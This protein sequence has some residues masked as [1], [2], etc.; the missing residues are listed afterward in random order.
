MRELIITLPK[1]KMDD[2]KAPLEV[3]RSKL[4]HMQYGE[5]RS[6]DGKVLL[7]TSEL[8]DIKNRLIWLSDQ[9]TFEVVSHKNQKYLLALDKL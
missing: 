8:G 5:L 2:D 9:F 7:R 1:I 6:R 4:P 3:E